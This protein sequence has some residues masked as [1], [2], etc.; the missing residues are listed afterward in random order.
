MFGQTTE[1]EMMAAVLHDVVEDTPITLEDLQAAGY[2][3][4][5]IAA[6]DSLTRREDEAYESY[7]ERC[8][9]NPIGLRVKLADMQDNMDIRRLQD[10]RDKDLARLQKYIKGWHYLTGGN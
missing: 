4:E 5:V 10:L 3:P 1:Y 6:V 8:R 9:A 7:L 2:P